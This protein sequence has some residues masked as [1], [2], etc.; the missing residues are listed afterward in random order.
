V[1]NA[2]DTRYFDSTSF[3]IHPQAPRQVVIGLSRRF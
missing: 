3:N 1:K 2:G